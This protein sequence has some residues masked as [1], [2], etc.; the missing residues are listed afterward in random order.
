MSDDWMD[1][2]AS[3][4]RV[5][6]ARAEKKWSRQAVLVVWSA[7]RSH[8]EGASWVCASPDDQAI[9]KHCRRIASSLT[10]AQKTGSFCATSRPASTRH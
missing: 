6:I 1:A 2:Q 9:P 10:R 4:E 5:C 7:M 8:C 3:A